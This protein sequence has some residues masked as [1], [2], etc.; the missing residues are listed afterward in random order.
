MESRLDTHASGNLAPIEL[1]EIDE[2]TSVMGSDGDELVELEKESYMEER[3]FMDWDKDGEFNGKEVLSNR[4]F[5][6]VGMEHDGFGVESE[7]GFIQV[8]THDEINDIE[9]LGWGQLRK[10][11]KRLP[12]SMRVPMVIVG[13]ELRK[14]KWDWGQSELGIGDEDDQKGRKRGKVSENMEIVSG[15]DCDVKFVFGEV[16]CN[17]LNLGVVEKYIFEISYLR[18]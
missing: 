4:R 11:W 18:I 12:V 3:E 17:D 7:L 5:T 15:V 16:G 1:P 14:R 8:T 9:G 13:D 2:N 10:M 6:V